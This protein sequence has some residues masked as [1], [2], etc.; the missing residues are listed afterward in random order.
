MK[1]GGEA[2]SNAVVVEMP[3]CNDHIAMLEFRK[4]QMPAAFASEQALGNS[5]ERANGL[6]R[7]ISE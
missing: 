7:V 1:G 4:Y 5:S 6:W 2:T 3:D